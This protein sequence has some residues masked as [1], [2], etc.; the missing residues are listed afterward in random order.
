MSIELLN[1]ESLGEVKKLGISAVG[2]TGNGVSA[3]GHS[4][5]RASGI[6]RRRDC[7]A[8]YM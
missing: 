4:P 7:D 2:I 1:Y 5:H 6:A 8:N 3:N